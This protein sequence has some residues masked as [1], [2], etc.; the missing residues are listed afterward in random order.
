[1]PPEGG[2]R[3]QVPGHQCL[4]ARG[5]GFARRSIDRAAVRVGQCLHPAGVVAVVVRDQDRIEVQVLGLQHLRD[6]CGIAGVNHG[7]VAGVHPVE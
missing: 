3:D 1:M 6:T 4:G 5:N 2:Q 7:N